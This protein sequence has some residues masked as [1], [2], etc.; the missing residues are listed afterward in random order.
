[1][2]VVILPIL[3][4]M[5]PLLGREQWGLAVSNHVCF[6]S[7]TAWGRAAGLR[8]HR[9]QFFHWGHRF[10]GSTFFSWQWCIPPPDFKFEQVPRSAVSWRLL[11]P[12]RG[13]WGSRERGWSCWL[14]WDGGGGDGQHHRGAHELFCA[15]ELHALPVPFPEAQ[16]GSREERG[17]RC[18]DEPAQVRWARRGCWFRFLVSACFRFCDLVLSWYKNLGD[19]MGQ[20]KADGLGIWKTCVQTPAL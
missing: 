18:R 13:S 8:Y 11:Q 1:M 15:E 7:I 10:L 20:K 19:T 16:L 2:P 17:Q 6:L 5:K 3:P 4:T 12:W 9:V 14:R